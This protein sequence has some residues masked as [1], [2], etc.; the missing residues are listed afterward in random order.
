MERWELVR[1]NEFFDAFARTVQLALPREGW[2]F[3]NLLEI[4]DEKHQLRSA[5]RE[6]AT[7]GEKEMIIEFLDE[8]Y[9]NNTEAILDG[10]FHMVRQGIPMYP[11]LKP[12]AYSVRDYSSR[13]RDK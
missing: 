11:P 12:F 13:L 2:S 5:V 3:L 8:S 4:D 10:V 9:F 7:G 6:D 1:T